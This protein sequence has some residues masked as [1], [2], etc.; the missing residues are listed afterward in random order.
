MK[1]ALF[2]GG[3]G[4]EYAISLRSA[5]AVL[6]A[7]PKKHTVLPIGITTAG[8]WF[9]CPD[10]TP[11]DIGRD[12]WQ[13]GRLLPVSFSPNQRALIL[14]DTPSSFDC[15]F[16]LLHGRG[17]ED[18]SIQGLLDS[19]RI[20]YVGCGVR[21]SAIG[22]DK[23]VS[24]VIAKEQGIPIA[25]FCTLHGKECRDPAA[26]EE[27][28]KAAGLS[29][30]LFLKPVSSGSSVGA[31]PINQREELPKA[32]SAAAS[33]GDAVLIEEYI[34]GCEVECAL[35]ERDGELFGRAVGEIEP[36]SRFYDYD[37]KYKSQ[38]SRI[39]IPARLPCAKIAEVRGYAKRLFRAFG[40]R[41]LSRLDFFVKKNGEVV[42]N[43]IN[44]MPGFTDISM[45]PMLM[46]VVGLSMCSLLET[47]LENAVV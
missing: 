43:E 18:G 22:M 23:V 37:T 46:G 10:A 44:T 36:G 28:I 27:K 14:G 25:A 15:A 19:C 31:S 9:A 40:C 4:E 17:G 6:S 20:P 45:F 33:F 32:L 16:P 3:A 26:A 2:F 12:A 11:R 42:F 41:G 30:P 1:V 35:I 47:L 13:G 24:K 38:T 8:R 39:F 34:E 21:A 29:Y 7:F 5:E